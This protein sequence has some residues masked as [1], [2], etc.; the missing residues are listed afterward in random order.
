MIQVG[1]R[2]LTPLESWVGPPLGYGVGRGVGT[3]DIKNAKAVH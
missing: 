1:L 2:E 3:V